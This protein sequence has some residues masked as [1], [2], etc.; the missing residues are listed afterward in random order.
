[1][2]GCGRDQYCRYFFSYC[3]PRFF[4]F[5][6]CPVVIQHVR[7]VEDVAA[8][9]EHQDNTNARPRQR[10][11]RQTS[12]GKTHPH[13]PTAFRPAHP[14]HVGD[15]RQQNRAN[16]PVDPEPDQGLE[17]WPVAVDVG[18]RDGRRLSEAVEI[19]LKSRRRQRQRRDNVQHHHEVAEIFV[20]DDGLHEHRQYAE[21][22]QPDQAD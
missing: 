9:A 10:S 7:V 1:M 11:S 13:P 5:E 16:P 18:I 8:D 6:G 21:N 3:A 22:P 12:G 20:V 14:H 15:D 4:D 17:K 19:V 2:R